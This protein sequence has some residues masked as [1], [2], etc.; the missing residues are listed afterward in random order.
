[1]GSGLSCRR[2]TKVVNDS[3]VMGVGEEAEEP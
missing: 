1:V 3:G 2:G